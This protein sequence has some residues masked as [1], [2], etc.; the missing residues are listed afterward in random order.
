VTSPPTRFTRIGGSLAIAIAAVAGLVVV[1][2][3]AGSAHGVAAGPITTSTIA[4]GPFAPDPNDP[5][6]KDTHWHAALGV[7]DCDHWMGDSSGP[8]IWSWPF[9][10][11]AGSPGRAANPDQ[12]A[13]LHSHDDGL[14]HMEPSAP[15]ESGNNATLGRYFEFGGWKLSATGFDFLGRG[16]HN[17]DSCGSMKGTFQWE[18]GT[19]DG[20]TGKQTYTVHTGDPASYKL[21]QFDIVVLAFLPGGMSISTLADPPSVPI[22]VGEMAGTPVP[23]VT[24]P[25]ATAAN[26]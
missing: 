3:C 19:W 11:S 18:V 15:D 9:A 13:G 23:G 14:I 5:T 20:T 1:S 21:H 16:A 10:S 4:I 17:G 24:V 26:G 12:Y 7:F 25:P 6:K 2:G 22:L 8:G